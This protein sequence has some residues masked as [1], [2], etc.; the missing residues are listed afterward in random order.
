M[1]CWTSNPTKLVWMTCSKNASSSINATYKGILDWNYISTCNVCAT[2]MTEPKQMSHKLRYPK[3]D[4]NLG[5]IG[6]RTDGRVSSL[7]KN[8]SEHKYRTSKVDRLVRSFKWVQKYCF[9]GLLAHSTLHGVVQCHFII[10]LGNN[11]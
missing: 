4:W 8:K 3:N 2:T 11:K 10:N 5:L 1:Q 9:S 7:S 6:W